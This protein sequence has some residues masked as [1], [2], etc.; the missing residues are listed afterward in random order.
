MSRQ[1]T[2][3]DFNLGCNET[4]SLFDKNVGFFSPN[5]GGCKLLLLFLCFLQTAVS[6]PTTSTNFQE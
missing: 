4:E 5:A 6:I 3:S 1:I 2:L